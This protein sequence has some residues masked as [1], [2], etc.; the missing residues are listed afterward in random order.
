METHWLWNALCDLIK[1]GGVKNFFSVF[2]NKLVLGYIYLHDALV[3]IT[4]NQ[5]LEPGLV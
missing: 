5:Q 2:K 1:K 4:D 3:K